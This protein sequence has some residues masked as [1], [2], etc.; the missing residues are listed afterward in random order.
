MPP[1]FGVLPRTTGQ[2]DADT[3]TRHHDL[4]STAGGGPAAAGPYAEAHLYIDLRPCG[5]G[6]VLFPRASAVIQAGNE[7]A[8]RYSG[9]ARGCDTYREFVF[10]LPAQILPSQP[11]VIAFGDGTPSELLDPGEWLWVADRYAR[12]F[13]ADVLDLDLPAR[14]QAR[15]TA[16]AAAAMDEVLT[17]VRAGGQAVPARAFRSE[18][19]REVYAREPGR[20]ARDRLVVVRDTYRQILAE[21][22]ATMRREGDR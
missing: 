10:R 2:N 20:F 16:T 7:L 22:R 17:F 14:Q 19:G 21:Q 15:N 4:P 12:V 18:R 5:C 11:E 8:S 6:E 3:F 1:G 13:P 9:Y